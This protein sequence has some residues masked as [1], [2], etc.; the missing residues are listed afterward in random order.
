MMKNHVQII[1]AGLS[2]AV[3]ARKYA[4]AG[5]KVLVIEKRN[6]TGGNCYDFYDKAGLLVPLYGPHFFHTDLA[7]V[8]DFVSHY[9]EWIPYEHRV[10]SHVDGK[11]VPV[12]VNI[13][14]VNILFG[15]HMK[16]EAEMKAW[17]DANTVHYDNPQNSEET[18]ISRVGP[19][20]YEKMFKNYTK[21]QWDLYPNELD[22]QVMSRIPVRTDFEDRYF[23]DS[24]QVMPKNGYRELFDHI[25][26]HKNIESL[27]DTDFL[28]NRNRFSKPEKLF[29][30]GKIDSYFDY[31]GLPPLQ[32]RSLRFEFET[33]ER[34]WFQQTA[35]INY[36]NN[37]DFTRITEPK[38][39]TGQKHSRTTIIREYPT[40][41]GEPYYPVINP[42]NDEIFSKYQTAAKQDEKNGVFFVGR[43]ANYK[44]FN[45]DAAIKNA[46][47]L[48]NIIEK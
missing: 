29:F 18:A 3:L 17:L 44:Y 30:T 1:G 33:L 19:V 14:T 12:P 4:E 2:G 24:W 38:H 34:E 46:L 25:F 28:K 41:E 43:L 47:E 26:D 27:L 23:T 21:K 39:A 35:T 36:P 16:T 22:A 37:H 5:K 32:Y 10:L 48:Y 40:W 9:C 6:H 7:D 15:L 11:L 13:N 42:K 45:M 8:R 31:L 20:L